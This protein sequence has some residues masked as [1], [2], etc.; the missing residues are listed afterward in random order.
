MDVDGEYHLRLVFTNTFRYLNG[1][2][3]LCKEYV[4]AYVRKPPPTKTAL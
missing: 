2:T 1:G 3:H 4:M